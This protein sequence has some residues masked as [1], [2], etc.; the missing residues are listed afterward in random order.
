[1]H[2]NRSPAH[3]S[4]AQLQTAQSQGIFILRAHAVYLWLTLPAV[5]SNINCKTDMEEQYPLKVEF[6]TQLFQL[7]SLIFRM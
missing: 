1:M 3:M 4:V 5:R 2:G 7:I 6:F